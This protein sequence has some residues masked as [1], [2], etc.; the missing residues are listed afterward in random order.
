VLSTSLFGL[1]FIGLSWAEHAVMAV[2]V[3]VGAS[4]G[5]MVLTAASNTVLQTVVEEEMCGHFL[6]LYTMVFVGFAALGSLMA[7]TEATY[8]GASQMVRVGDV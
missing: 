4:G 3:L 8:L 7:G 1:G 2:L 5:M 6:S